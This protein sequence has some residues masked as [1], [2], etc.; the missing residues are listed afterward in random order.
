M[1]PVWLSNFAWDLSINNIVW[2]NLADT[3][4]SSQDAVKKVLELKMQS[5]NTQTSEVKSKLFFFKNLLETW[6]TITIAS[7]PLF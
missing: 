3:K 7:H 6:Y 2:L 1:T 5:E 4:I